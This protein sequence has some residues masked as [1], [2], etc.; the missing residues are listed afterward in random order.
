[1]SEKT[2]EMTLDE[3][4]EGLSGY[5]AQ[6]SLGARNKRTQKYPLSISI[7]GQDRLQEASSTASKILEGN[8]LVSLRE[9]GAR[10]SVQGL[11][12]YWHE[13]KFIEGANLLSK[14]LEWLLT[15]PDRPDDISRLTISIIDAGPAILVGTESARQ[16]S[17][18][19][20]KE[21]GLEKP[22][23]EVDGDWEWWMNQSKEQAQADPWN[24]WQNN[25]SKKYDEYMR[26]LDSK[27]FSLVQQWT[28]LWMAMIAVEAF[29]RN[30]DLLEELQVANPEFIYWVSSLDRGEY[31][32][33]FYFIQTLGIEQAMKYYSEFFPDAA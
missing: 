28:E 10:I 23:L 5:S 27:S 32:M 24:R 31:E 19:K 18:E 15:L 9:V 22:I 1:M 14:R 3:V 21:I 13:M 33:F 26:F 6:I 20:Y 4:S 30:K 11:E 7:S 16:K 25:A 8:N 17:L 12:Q 29:H 2:L